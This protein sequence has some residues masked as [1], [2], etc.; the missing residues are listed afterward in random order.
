MF[1]LCN[2]DEVFNGRKMTSSVTERVW[3]VLIYLT[4]ELM[5]IIKLTRH[6]RVKW[7]HRCRRP[8]IKMD[9]MTAPKKWLAPG[10]WLQYG[11]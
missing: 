2:N 4:Y 1:L 7:I 5:M 3:L 6:K 11:S 8:V 9:D 10:G